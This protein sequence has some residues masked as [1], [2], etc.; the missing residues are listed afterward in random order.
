MEIQGDGSVLAGVEG[1]LALLGQVAWPG[2]H[3]CTDIDP[4]IWMEFC[5]SKDSKDFPVPLQ[6]FLLAASGWCSALPL[7]ALEVM[8]GGQHV[9]SR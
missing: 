3:S 1:A 9:L 5:T 2:L 4:G 6:L 7:C 8:P